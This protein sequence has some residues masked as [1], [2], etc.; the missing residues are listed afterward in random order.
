MLKNRQPEFQAMAKDRRCETCKFSHKES[1]YLELQCRRFPPGVV[2]PGS[3][4]ERV[5]ASGV[6]PGFDA[7]GGGV[8]FPCVKPDDWCGEWIGSVSNEG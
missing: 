2:M 8:D 3:F 7:V 1:D 5:S 4:V 6:R